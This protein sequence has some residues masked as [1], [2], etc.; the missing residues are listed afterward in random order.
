MGFLRDVGAWFADPAHWSGA[1][2]IPARTFEHLQISLLSVGIAALVAL[3]LGLYIGHT[4]RFEFLVTTAAN[5]GRAIPSFALLVAATPFTIRFGLGI[6]LWPT[7]FALVF[8]GIPPILTNTHV[9]VQSVD[10]DT[11]EAARGMG[12]TEREVLLRLEVPL[13]LPL[14]VAGIRTAAVQVVA[15]A[16]LAALIGWGGLGRFIVD[17][18]AVGERGHPQVFA[19]AVLVATLAILTEVAF[20]VVERAITPRTASRGRGRAARPAE[21]A[22]A[23]EAGVAGRAA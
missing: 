21:P 6:G 10:P 12:M 17:G 7:V 13:G 11:R 5:L 18:F 22:L 1:G 14:I 9:G 19:G 8:L 16:T 20:E 3:P 15:T 4:R 23:E 2:G